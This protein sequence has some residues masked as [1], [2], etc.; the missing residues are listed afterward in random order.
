[1]QRV[2]AAQA[3]KLIPQQA[4]PTITSSRL[5]RMKSPRSKLQVATMPNS[6]EKYKGP[7]RDPLEIQDRLRRNRYRLDLSARLPIL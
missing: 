7:T 6:P 1:M 5:R 2:N 3:G 4:S